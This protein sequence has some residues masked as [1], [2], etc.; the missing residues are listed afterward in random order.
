MSDRN[1]ET[2]NS[3][4]VIQDI[5]GPA[6]LWPYSIRRYLWPL[7]LRHFQRKLIAASVYVKGFNPVIFLDL[8][9]LPPLS[10]NG[11]LTGY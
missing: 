11:A 3:W 2:Y 10:F 9:H 1:R 4:T 8:V 6:N 5:V 7:N